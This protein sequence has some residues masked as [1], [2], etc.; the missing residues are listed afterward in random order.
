MKK[1]N[2]FTLIELMVTLV[3]A[4]I[5]ITVAVPGMRGMIESNK[6]VSAANSISSVMNLARS[7]AAKR[8]VNVTVCASNDS[9]QPTPG[10]AGASWQVGWVVWADLDKDGN[11]DSPGE[12]IQVGSALPASTNI[13]ATV[14][15]IAFDSTGFAS[16]ANTWKVC[17][18][19]SG[20]VGYEVKLLVS[21]ALSE[22]TQV[23]CP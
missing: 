14:T 9:D 5:L 17:D 12:V 21:G 18:S 19:G 23:A 10:C 22:S 20:N 13:T 1:Q 3:V 11:F 16:G 15:S 4:T 8:S 6:V 7:E 2:G